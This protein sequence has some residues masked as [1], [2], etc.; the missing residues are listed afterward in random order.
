MRPLRQKIIQ[1]KKKRKERLNRTTYRKQNKE[2]S[3][4]LPIIGDENSD[5]KK[6]LNN[7]GFVAL[8][9]CH[10]FS[11]EPFNKEN[12]SIY[13]L[14]K[15]RKGTKKT[16]YYHQRLHSHKNR[17]QVRIRGKNGE[18][19]EIKYVNIERSFKKQREAQDRR[20]Y[21]QKAK[22]RHKIQK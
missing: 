11:Q 17:T 7:T 4:I 20:Q 12:N 22:Q 5:K 15:S 8:E 2:G 14:T 9:D 3:G 16:K 21:I 6:M 1:H 19:K 18:H 10:E 13:A